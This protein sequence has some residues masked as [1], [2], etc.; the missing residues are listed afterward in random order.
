MNSKYKQ[1]LQPFQFENGVQL[2]NRIVMA[3]MTNFS[4]NDDGT[5]TK[6][7]IDYYSRRSGGPGMVITA[8]AYVT[9]SG[10][11][12]PGEFGS[13][14][15][16][17]IP[18]LKQLAASIKEKGAKAIMQIFHGGRMVPAELVPGGDVVSASAVPAE[19]GHPSGEAPVP[20]AL[21]ID[22]IHS[23]IDD[24]GESTRRAIQAG[25][26]G[27]EIHGANGYLIQQFVS[28]HSNRREDEFGGSLE[29]RLAFPLAVIDSVKKTAAEFGDEN[30][31][32]GYRFSPEEPETPGITME[33][34]LALVDA[35]KEKNLDYLHI[36]LMEYWSAPRR[37][38]DD[39]RSRL[40]IIQERVGDSVPLI[41]VG[42]I[43]TPEDAVR[44]MNTGV[45]LIALGR[46][47][48]IE[49]DWVQKME[50]GREDKIETQLDKQAQDRLVVPDPLWQAIINTP[51][52]FP[53]K[54]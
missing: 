36:S 52:W 9:P 22:E 1:L 7:E 47:L 5:V 31:L 26:D 40:E 49:P 28:P 44:A 17:M 19:Q 3:P 13:D 10:K 11:G 46:E 29:K 30:F 24:F 27:V 42:S 43:Y 51:G 35:L 39:T 38:I 16:D 37:G 18:S 15:D 34:T 48:I 8:C 21:T 4:S 41:G 20:R 33:D 32:V 6:E 14:T 45:P 50:E 12:F 54:E 2:K 25:F 53:V 23:I